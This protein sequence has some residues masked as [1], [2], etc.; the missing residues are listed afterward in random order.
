MLS[1]DRVAANKEFQ[2]EDELFVHNKHDSPPAGHRKRRATRSVTC[3]SAICY[4]GGGGYPS[5]DLFGGTPILSWWGWWI[6]RSCPDREGGGSP[7]LSWLE[8]YPCPGY[9]HLGLGYPM[10]G[11]VVP[12]ALDWGSPIRTGLGYSQPASGVPPPGT[13]VLTTSRDMRPETG[14]GHGNSGWK[15]Y[16]MEMGTPCGGQTENITFRHSSDAGGNNWFCHDLGYL[17][18]SQNLSKNIEKLLSYQCCPERN[19][20]GKHFWFLVVAVPSKLCVFTSVLL[21]EFLY[22]FNK[23]RPQI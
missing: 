10:P 16:G 19:L 6:T 22:H 20:K 17:K 4:R 5:T 21:S 2:H 14:K 9:P 12:P 15:Y 23:L 18:K 13:G 1:V 8:G 11:T 7:I 3:P